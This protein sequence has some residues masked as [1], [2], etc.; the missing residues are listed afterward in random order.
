MEEPVIVVVILTFERRQLL[1][2]RPQRQSARQHDSILNA[3]RCGILSRS[4]ET[5]EPADAQARDA[6]NR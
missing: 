5:P 4:I 3:L 1:H 2:R 6:G